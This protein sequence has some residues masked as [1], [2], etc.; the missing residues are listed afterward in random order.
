MKVRNIISILLVLLII[1]TT[2]SVA[3]AA[4]ESSITTYWIPDNVKELT[5]SQGDSAKL[6][7]SANTVKP[8]IKVTLELHQNGKLV[9]T[10]HNY[11][12]LNKAE[13]NY[14]TVFQIPGTSKLEG[15]YTIIATANGLKEEKPTTLTVTKANN[16]PTFDMKN[17]YD[18]TVGEDVKI[19]T[20]AKD[21]DGDAVNVTS[22][23]LPDGLKIE[24]NN[25]VGK[26]TKAGEY[27]VTV[28]A[29]D[30]KTKTNKE[31][32]I[33]VKEPKPNT[34]PTIQGITGKLLIPESEKTETLSIAA[35]DA[36][37]D[38]LTYE[39][40]SCEIKPFSICSGFFGTYKETL[41]TGFTQ[42]SEKLEVKTG[43]DY[44]KHYWSS[45]IFDP[46]PKG[47][48]SKT[49]KFR[50][51]VSDSE[52]SSAWYYQTIK[53]T[54]TNRLPK[55]NGNFQAQIVDEGD[56]VTIPFTTSDADTEDT[57]KVSINPLTEG[58]KIENNALVWEVQYNQE[59][60][61]KIVLEATDGIDTVTQE[62]N[63]NVNNKNQPPYFVTIGNTNGV[64]KT[65]FEVS[66]GHELSFSV[67]AA[68]PD[69]DSLSINA[70]S[71]ISNAQFSKNRFTWT[72]NENQVGEY[73]V[74]VQA[75]DGNWLTSE[76]VRIFVK[77]N[78]APTLTVPPMNFEVGK[79]SSYTI[80]V[81]DPENDQTTLTVESADGKIDNTRL[82]TYLNGNIFTWKPSHSEY[83]FQPYEVVF[84]ATDSNGKK[85]SKVAQLT[86][87]TDDTDGDGVKDNGADGIEHT[88]DDDNCPTIA[89]PLQEDAD[90]GGV[91]DA[92]DSNHKPE[93]KIEG[94]LTGK[95]GQPMVIFIR[96]TDKDKDVIGLNIN[97][98]PQGA[99]LTET[100]PG[101]EWQLIWTPGYDQAGEH[102]VELA[103]VDTLNTVFIPFKIV[104]ENT[105]RAPVIT[106]TPVTT[107]TENQQYE[108]QVKAEDP[109]GDALTYSFAAKPAGMEV[110][111]E[112]KITWTASAGAHTVEIIVTDALGERTSQIYTISAV[113][114]HNNIRI[115]KV[116]VSNEFLHPGEVLQVN[117]DFQ[118]KGNTDFKDVQAT[119][120]IYDLG[121]YRSTGEFNLYEG[122]Q[123]SRN[124]AVQ[125]PYEAPAGVYLVKITASN[126]R[127]HETSYRQI[128]II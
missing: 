35:S 68:D 81:T 21:A 58:A 56:T 57:V 19:E 93:Y 31:I 117:M 121:I 92:C 97:Q 128:R 15:K 71:T 32:T 25:I 75:D 104:I 61:Q 54:D 88:T 5:I 111:P 28:T 77:E 120:M 16:A 48:K 96:V 113:R 83:T 27:K 47:Q 114:E 70:V 98:I 22:T 39:V 110:T 74:E 36:D 82:A 94:P 112:G 80:T 1:V 95:E 9:E 3:L 109:D 34:A 7:V 89:N 67:R 122:S 10:L 99:Q 30:G 17:S 62:I 38:K 50:F 53:V 105:N 66:Q 118:N 126:D 72:P 52:D 73:I 8:P 13:K 37:G 49:I 59:G 60:P 108:Y 125:V 86:I 90:D 29:D 46:T 101:E 106:S 14:D 44:L 6:Q 2:A 42:N 23:T 40:E 24:N 102:P 100:Q 20:N 18:A 55:L 127:F 116:H 64:V 107:A 115:S 87:T 85:T 4:P 11:E 63:F 119:V 103:L 12:P 69:G 26:P 91:G 43:Y 45:N 76:Q 123:K 124:L 33:F 65:E 84:T 79:E 78:G 41:P 51:R